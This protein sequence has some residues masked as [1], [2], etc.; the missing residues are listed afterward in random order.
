VGEPTDDRYFLEYTFGGWN[1]GYQLCM[2]VTFNGVLMDEGC[3]DELP[4]EDP[5]SAKEWYP[6]EGIIRGS[7]LLELA[8]HA[9]NGPI[10]LLGE[11]VVRIWQEIPGAPNPT[12]EATFVIAEDCS[13]YGF[14]P[15]PGSILLLGSG[16]AGLAGYAAL[17]LR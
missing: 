12:A 4:D 8:A 15:E 6:C 16:L 13:G 5:S 10:S 7:S 3:S 9:S 11:W 2:S 17:R 1:P 14:V